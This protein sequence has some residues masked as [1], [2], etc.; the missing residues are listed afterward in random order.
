MLEKVNPMGHWNGRLADMILYTPVHAAATSPL[1]LTNTLTGVRHWAAV[2]RALT[3]EP[4]NESTPLF[5]HAAATAP[6]S[7]STD[8]DSGRAHWLEEVSAVILEPE[9]EMIPLP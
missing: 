1:R 2:A 9:M 3:E 6:V 4:A 7:P 8:T 5:W